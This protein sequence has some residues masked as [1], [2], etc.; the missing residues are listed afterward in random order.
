VFDQHVEKEWGAV[1]A[2]VLVVE[3]ELGNE[4][5]VLAIDSLLESSDG[6]VGDLSDDDLLSRASHALSLL[7]VTDSGASSEDLED[8]NAFVSVDFVTRR[9]DDAFLV[10]LLAANGRSLGPVF[11]L[12]VLSDG[13]LLDKEPEAV[14]AHP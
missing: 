2:D 1:E 10:M 6:A 12:E 5:E 3:E 8:G 14:L 9:N 7:L 4:A 11:V 13:P